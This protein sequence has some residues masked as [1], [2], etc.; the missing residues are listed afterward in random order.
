MSKVA[1]RIDAA[2]AR[3]AAENRSALIPF[4]MGG[5]PDYATS[6][7]V[8]NK[9][10]AA[11]ADIIEL[12]VPFSDPMADG[13][14][15]QAAGLR[16][17]AAGA[18]LARVLEQV[19]EFRRANT[20]TP[21]ILMGYGNPFFHYG[22]DRF[23]AD[24]SHAGVDGVIIVDVPPEEESGFAPALA[25]AGLHFVRLIAPPSLSTRLP[26]LTRQASG[27]L[28]LVSVAGITGTASASAETIREYM[29]HIRRHTNLPVAVG[30]GIKTPADVR[31]LNRHVDGIVVGSSIVSLMEHA[32]ADHGNAALNLVQ[33]MAAGLRE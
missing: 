22:M 18:T 2:F 26:A 13:P 21:I 10:P 8:L 5:D 6:L 33:Q 1:S 30:F 17:R 31:A 32:A 4:I 29:Q 3:A 23:A 7:A 24:A 9:L 11:G 15:I 25:A 14:I 28:Y 20:S 16:A 19:R 12:G 27:Y